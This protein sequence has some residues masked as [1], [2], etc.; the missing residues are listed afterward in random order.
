MFRLSPTILLLCALLLAACG[1][2]PAAPARD[3]APGE[4]AASP[5]PSAATSE[6]APAGATPTAPPR[7]GGSGNPTRVTL[8]LGY[9]PDVQ[10]APFY[11]AVRNGYYAEEGLEVEFRHLGDAD[12]LKLAGTGQLDYAVASGDEM[13][14]ARSQG[15]PLVYVGAYFHQYPVALIAPEESG[16]TRV[17]QVRGKTIGI[18]GQYGA[19]YNG[20]R[21]LLYAAG[22]DESDVTLRS[23]S[24]TQVQALERGQVDAVMGYLNNEPLQLR[25]L[26]MAVRTFPVSESAALVSNGV[27]TNEEQLESDPEQV[28]RVVRATMRGLEAAIADPEAAYEASLAHV[29]EAGGENREAQ[30]AVLRASVPLWRSEAAAEHGAGYTAP[31]DWAAT[32][33][34]LERAGSLAGE[35]DVE[36]A[37]TNRFITKELAAP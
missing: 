34:F 20:V 3:G 4:T 15:V 2:R 36:A 32:R 33:D 6:D 30:L 29:P 25:R 28:Q 11:L 37:Y 5:P 12:L 14:V 19:T 1:G 24:F 23:I 18:P 27:V 26:G 13:L 7:A 16:I 10:F 8:G 31:E 22:L 17:E 21:A 9:K 35:V